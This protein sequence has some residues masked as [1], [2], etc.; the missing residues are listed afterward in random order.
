MFSSNIIVLLSGE[1]DTSKVTVFPLKK[2]LQRQ[3]ADNFEVK[4]K[5]PVIVGNDVWVGAGAII[6]SGVKIGSGAI[7]GAGAVVVNDVPPYAIVAGNPARIIK[8]RFTQEQIEKL[9]KIGWW[10]W[11][12]SKIRENIDYFYRDVESFINKF[13][14]SG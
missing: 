6:L 5:G 7:V 13:G 2:R 9:L 11:E 12:E 1:H 10:D 8:F 14:A 3:E 4:S